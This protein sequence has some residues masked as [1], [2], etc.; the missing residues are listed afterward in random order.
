MVSISVPGIRKIVGDKKENTILKVFYQN[1]VEIIL[2]KDGLSIAGLVFKKN[3]PDLEEFQLL[4]NEQFVN[5][6]N[7]AVTGE[8]I[9]EDFFELLQ[10]SSKDNINYLCEKYLEFNVYK[11]ETLDIIADRLFDAMP[12]EDKI[13][14]SVALNAQIIYNKEEEKLENYQ[15]NLDNVSVVK[16]PSGKVFSSELNG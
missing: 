4:T 16:T 8:F 10:N 11:N 2:F 14:N 9:L 6:A 7:Q 1:R 13:I 15:S 5:L 3:D 12:D